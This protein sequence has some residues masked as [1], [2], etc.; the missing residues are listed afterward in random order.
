MRGDNRISISKADDV[1]KDPLAVA[2]LLDVAYYNKR[3][4]SKLKKDLNLNK[5]EMMILNRLYKWD[6]LRPNPHANVKDVKYVLAPKGY[7]LV[8]ELKTENPT[9]LKDI[10]PKLIPPEI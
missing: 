8:N 1:K 6:Y 7:F 9:L 4:T 2:V 3:E 5:K 10:Q